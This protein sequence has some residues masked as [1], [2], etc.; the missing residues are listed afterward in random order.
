MLI[1]NLLDA[2]KAVLRG[3][4]IMI[5]PYLRKNVKISNKQ[6]NLT[7]HGTGKIR[8]NLKLEGNKS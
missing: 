5:Q 2:A 8:T 4:I 1:Q 7:L 3:I 6:T